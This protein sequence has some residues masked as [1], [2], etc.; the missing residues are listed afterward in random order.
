LGFWI[1]GVDIPYPRPGA[2]VAVGPLGELEKRVT[3]SNAV[4]DFVVRQLQ[5]L[6][7]ADLVGIL[8]SS[9]MVLR[10]ASHM[11]RRYISAP[12][13][14]HHSTISERV[15]LLHVVPLEPIM[16]RLLAR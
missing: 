9:P 16:A 6:A 8:G 3:L 5:L 14:Y 12:L 15:S 2:P 10:L 7:R 11:R 13:P 4:A 1:Q